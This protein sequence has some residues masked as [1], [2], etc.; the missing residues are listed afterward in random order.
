MNSSFV[1]K[2]LSSPGSSPQAAMDVT[3]PVQSTPP[4]KLRL[5]LESVKNTPIQSLKVFPFRVIFVPT[6]G[7]NKI[8]WFIPVSGASPQGF[9]PILI[10]IQL[11]TIWP[12]SS[13]ILDGLEEF[14]QY[15]VHTLV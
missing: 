4:P 11:S 7:D 12:K 2:P 5:P 14:S 10:A 13:L 1:A 6:A 3:S 8:V 9:V 15:D